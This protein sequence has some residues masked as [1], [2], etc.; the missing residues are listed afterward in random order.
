MLEFEG[1]GVHQKEDTLNFRIV[2]TV[3]SPFRH[4]PREIL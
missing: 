2:S 4:I 3:P 1:E